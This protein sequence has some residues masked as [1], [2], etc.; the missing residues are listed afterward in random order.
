MCILQPVT[1]HKM[2]CV[3]YNGSYL[4]VTML[5][6]LRTL[7]G[8]P[9]IAPPYDCVGKSGERVAQMTTSF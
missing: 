1:S 6:I 5:V 3:G 2:R 9:A 4:E 8:I 7:L